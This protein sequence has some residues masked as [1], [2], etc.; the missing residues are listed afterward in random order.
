MDTGYLVWTRVSTG[1][2]IVL[3]LYVD[4]RIMI[5]SCSYLGHSGVTVLISNLQFKTDSGRKYWENIYKGDLNQDS[6]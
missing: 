1:D 3:L 5:L 4:I 2:G 6:L